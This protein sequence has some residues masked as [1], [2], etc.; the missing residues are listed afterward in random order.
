LFQVY[1]SER[2]KTDK[3]SAKRAKTKCLG[4]PSLVHWWHDVQ[5][6]MHEWLYLGRLLCSTAAFFL[7]KTG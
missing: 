6:P 5:P 7:A 2:G 4:V 1:L 3:K